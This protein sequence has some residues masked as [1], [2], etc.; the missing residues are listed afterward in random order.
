MF[1]A[2]AAALGSGCGGAPAKDE[3]LAKTAP[4]TGVIMYKGNPLK[5]AVVTFNPTGEGNPGVGRTEENGRF[6][7]TTYKERDGA[8][9]GTHIVTVQVMPVGGLPGQEVASTGGSDIPAKY[10]DT[11]TSPLSVEVKEGSNNL[12][13]KIED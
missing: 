1:T 7:L 13:L 3:N 5:D 2:L 10:A 12:E 6:I 4:V 11:K 8:A 9:V